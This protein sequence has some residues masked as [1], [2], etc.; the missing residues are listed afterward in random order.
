MASTSSGTIITTT[1]ATTRITSP[2][3]ISR[4]TG[5]RAALFQRRSSLRSMAR[6]G[7][8]STNAMAQPSKKGC[9]MPKNTRSQPISWTLCCTP[10]TSA[11]ARH[12]SPTSCFI[13]LRLNSTVGYTPFP[14]HRPAP[15][16]PPPVYAS[17][18]FFSP[19]HSSRKRCG[20]QSERVA[21]IC[22]LF[23]LRASVPP[24]SCPPTAAVLQ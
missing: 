13:I 2:R 1:S 18:D 15:G 3:L 12:S 21:L 5:R 9:T 20:M 10:H 4:D 11:A 16:R 17:F 19:F 7:R 24:P 14:R 22:K 8:L 6:S 23:V